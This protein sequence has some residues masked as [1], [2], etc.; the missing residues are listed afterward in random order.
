M[1]I[2]WYGGTTVRLREAGRTVVVDPPAGSAL[3]EQ[4]DL[5]AFS[6]GPGIPG[7][8]GFTIAGPGEYE[9]GGVFVVGVAVDAERTVYS[10]ALGDLAV[11]H[12]GGALGVLDDAQCEAVGP[13]DVLLVPVT[14]PPGVT[15]EQ[16]VELV[17]LLEPALVVPMYGDETGPDADLERFLKEMAVDAPEPVASLD[18]QPSRLPDEPQVRV[19]RTRSHLEGARA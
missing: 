4:S 16:A 9:V 7:G 11:A 2:D 5:V 6:S 19:L 15:P 17:N 1:D 8:D 13:I 12:L 3:V 14:G 10:F 18:V